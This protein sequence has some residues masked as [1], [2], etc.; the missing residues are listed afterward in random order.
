MQQLWRELMDEV[1]TFYTKICLAQFGCTF[2]DNIITA[3][4]EKQSVAAVVHCLASVA[5]DLQIKW[6]EWAVG[7]GNR[8]FLFTTTKPFLCP[9]H[10][11]LDS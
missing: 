5:N 4:Q 2:N 7:G 9:A 3:L 6:V 8:V 11:P 10:N 1:K